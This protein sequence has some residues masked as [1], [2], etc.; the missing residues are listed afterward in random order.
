MVS[1]GMKED[2]E[3]KEWKYFMDNRQE[4]YVPFCIPEISFLIADCP[5]LG[6]VRGLSGV[7]L[8]SAWLM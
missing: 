4:D 8:Q 5:G 2:I 3:M 6:G 1:K 7:S